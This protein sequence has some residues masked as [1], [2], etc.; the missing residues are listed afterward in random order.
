MTLDWWTGCLTCCPCHVVL[1]ISSLFFA[2][3]FGLHR[4]G[5]FEKYGTI[6]LFPFGCWLNFDRKC[7][8][9]VRLHWLGPNSA[10]TTSRS[11]TYRLSIHFSTPFLPSSVCI[12]TSC[13]PT[14]YQTGFALILSFVHSS[15]G[16]EMTKGR[17][18]CRWIFAKLCWCC[19]KG[20]GGLSRWKRM[21]LVGSQSLL[22]L[23]ACFGPLTSYGGRLA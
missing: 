9:R 23:F 21:W 4:W 12:Q 16:S 3:S 15:C 1:N 22:G 17:N 7:A 19:F 6:S 8:S 10:L 13:C 20:W 5:G 11:A 14:H 18:G 2:G